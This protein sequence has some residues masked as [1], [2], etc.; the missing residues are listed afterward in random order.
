MRQLDIGLGLICQ[1]GAYLLQRRRSDPKIGAAGLIGV[2]GGKVESGETA[3][4]A[5]CRELGEETNLVLSPEEFTHLGEVEILS[6]HQLEPVQVHAT[7]YCVTVSKM[8]VV[9]AKEGTLVLLTK[10]EALAKSDELS[11]ATRAC[12]EQLI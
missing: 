5:T 3:L 7:V 11:A 9:K 12:F 2:F 10:Q 1:E 6:D 8:K 4:E